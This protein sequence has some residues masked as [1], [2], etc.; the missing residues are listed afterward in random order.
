MKTAI[1]SD[2]H[3]VSPVDVVNGLKDF[4][5][6]RFA[7][8]GDY[9][10]PSVL[11]DILALDVDKIVLVGNHDHSFIR[12]KNLSSAC[13]KGP[14]PTFV[15]KWAD[16]PERQFVNACS[17][18]YRG[19]KYGMSVVDG[20][21]PSTLYVHGALVSGKYSEQGIPEIWGRLADPEATGFT[22]QQRKF[23]NL[24]EMKKRGYEF[25]FRGHDHSQEIVSIPKDDDFEDFSGI[26]TSRFGG[27]LE[28]DKRHIVTVGAFCEG[29]YTIYD[30]TTGTVSFRG[31]V[32]P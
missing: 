2:F 30:D 5:I 23:S 32:L 22:P 11:R 25:M 10:D 15:K 16:C 19:W 9:D 26:T 7:F 3:S 4:G 21:N 27:K 6:D 18:V 20:A 29:H 8:L 14:S 31:V 28:R 13:L 24:R 17:G 12:G 1:M